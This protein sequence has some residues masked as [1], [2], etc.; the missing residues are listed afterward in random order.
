L[1]EFAL[2]LTQQGTQ[3][4]IAVLEGGVGRRTVSFVHVDCQRLPLAKRLMEFIID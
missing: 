4:A 2:W 3:G 1:R